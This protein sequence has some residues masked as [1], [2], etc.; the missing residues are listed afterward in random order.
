[1]KKTATK[2]DMPDEWALFGEIWNIYKMFRFA[3]AWGECVKFVE[4]IANH[5][6]KYRGSPLKKMQTDMI[7]AL[8]DALDP[9]FVKEEPG[10]N[11]HPASA[12]EVK[13][14]QVVFA[15][16]LGFMR[17]Y[18][19]CETETDKEEMER[20]AD[21]LWKKHEPSYLCDGLVR[22]VVNEL[23]RRM[24]RTEMTQHGNSPV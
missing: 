8:Q 18:Y 21:E 24:L 4:T 9:L 3:K 11:F 10:I 1:M 23:D 16:V 20:A 19:F 15:D 12:A 13:E 14:E 17:T 5:H 2:A 7:H 6:D 22:A